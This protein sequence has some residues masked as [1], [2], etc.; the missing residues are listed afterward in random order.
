[1][2]PPQTNILDSL[3]A[4]A[5]DLKAVLANKD[6]YNLQIIYTKIDRDA[7]NKPH[8][9]DYTFN[10]NGHYFYP[11]STVKLPA[12]LLALERL[13]H[14]KK[15]GIDKYT[16]MITDSS[17]SL[18]SATDVNSKPTI[19]NYI[20]EIFLVSDND[21][22]NRL[23]EFLGQNYFNSRLQSKDYT[24]ADI[25]HRLDIFL[26]EDQNRHTN[27]VSFYD[28]A[29]KLLYQQAQ[30]INTKAYTKR[31]NKAGKGY[32]RNNKLFDEPFDFSAKNKILLHDL[33]NMLRAVIFPEA[34]PQKQR[35][36]LSNDDY[37]FLYK[38]MSA[39]PRE[40]K[41]PHY[42]SSQYP[43]AYGKFLMFGAEKENMPQNI[44]IFNKIGDAYGFLND[45]AYI[46]DLENHVEFM[47]SATIFC[48]S[49]GIFNDEKYDYE[50]VGFP[51]MKKLGQ[52]VYD[53][54]KQRPRKHAADLSKFVID[55][56]E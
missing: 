8:F 23:Y 7:S 44:R 41:F 37:R 52:L 55:Y 16:T 17:Y 51:F 35:F 6:S 30:Q 3:L 43:D 46:V 40:S 9:T 13:N 39:R 4:N 24:S 47:L 5:T 27:T 22:F 20:K 33:H 15:Y 28:T 14:L 54:E 29:G 31:E 11:A 50:T 26:T 34:V 48:N 53:F 19:A 1:M 38:W 49:D 2:K 56:K 45:V 25:R 32:Y 10:N 21:A 36:D 12:S 42:D 18:K